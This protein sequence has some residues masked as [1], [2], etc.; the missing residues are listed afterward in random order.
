MTP[1]LL[2]AL[3][4]ASPTLESADAPS[5]ER[6]TIDRIFGGAKV[7]PNQW[8]DTAALLDSSGEPFCTGTLI[9]PRAVLTAA[10]CVSQGAPETI[11]LAS[12]DLGGGERLAVAHAFAYPQWNRTY[13]LAVVILSE[14]ASTPPRTIGLDCVLDDVLSDGKAVTLVGYG[15]TETNDNNTDKNAVT[16]VLTDHDCSDTAAYECNDEISPGGEL[17]AGGDGKDSCFGDSGG[18]VYAAQ[19]AQSYLVG[20]TSRGAKNSGPD[21]GEEGIYVRFDAAFAWI[22]S[23]AGVTLERPECDSGGPAPGEN[24][25]VGDP[26]EPGEGGGDSGGWDSGG[27]W[28]T[29][30]PDEVD[31]DE[32]R[33]VDAD[34]KDPTTEEPKGCGCNGG[35]QMAA[36]PAFVFGLISL[37]GRRRRS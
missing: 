16:T 36:M 21:C 31:P 15:V 13:D 12:A 33:P 37:V 32:T 34:P 8:Q 29:G 11:L 14:T 19:G 35:A 30:E 22:E 6:P 23:A 1:L 27:D 24:P 26:I 25:P 20:V 2:S 9:A 5:V 4:F 18:P 10:H 28:D 7:Q 3:A 17:V